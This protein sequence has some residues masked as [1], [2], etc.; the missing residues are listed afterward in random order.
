[1]YQD[2]SSELLSHMLEM[3]TKNKGSNVSEKKPRPGFAKLVLDGFHTLALFEN[4][5]PT[6]RFAIPEPQSRFYTTQNSPMGVL[7][8]V[9]IA[10]FVAGFDEFLNVT[11]C[12]C[13]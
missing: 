12:K 1:M 10:E 3:L 13:G 6:N 4:R 8:D 2:N 7:S 5:N 9:K 11:F